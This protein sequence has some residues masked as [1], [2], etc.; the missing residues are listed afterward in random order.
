MTES[1][2]RK[3]HRQ[4][5]EFHN[6]DGIC[7]SCAGPVYYKGDFIAIVIDDDDEKS[8]VVPIDAFMCPHCSK[9]IQAVKVY[10]DLSVT[11]EFARLSDHGG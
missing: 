8:L 2:I 4:L 10:K 3:T 6:Y 11:D 1:L 5:I 7:D 9:I